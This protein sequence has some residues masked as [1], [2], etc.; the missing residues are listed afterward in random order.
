MAH[1]LELSSSRDLRINPHPFIRCCTVEDRREV[2]D[3]GECVVCIGSTALVS[4]KYAFPQRSCQS[5]VK[6][7]INILP[8]C[9]LYIALALKGYSNLLVI[10]LSYPALR[11][12]A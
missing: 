5:I 8:N 11:T 7:K 10:L 9:L 1:G 2:S 6:I 12:L 4:G 3:Q